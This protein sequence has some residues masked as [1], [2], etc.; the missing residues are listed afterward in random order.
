MSAPPG[1]S[2]RE[3]LAF[4]SIFGW[5][6]FLR[7]KHVSMAGARFRIFRNGHSRR[8]YVFIHG[9]EET[10][11]GVLLRHIKANQGIA[12]MVESRTRTVPCEAGRI[13]PN[14]MFSRVGAA[15]S[16]KHLNPDWPQERVEAALAKLDHQRDHL[17]HALLPPPGGLL[18]ALHN[19]SAAYSVT[20]EVPISDAKS[21][22]E[23]SNPHAF[24]LCTDPADFALLA[25]SGYNVVLQQHTPPDDDG[26]LS[27]LAAVRGARYVNLEVAAGHSGRQQEMLDWLEWMLP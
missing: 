2:R 22:R 19:N 21:L 3:F 1:E 10:A 8:R 24:F 11:R 25:T 6:P 9:D 26:S 5:I 23:P 27:R 18:V 17:V 12:Y 13:D 14:R 20:D 16:L 7:P 4:G 15:A